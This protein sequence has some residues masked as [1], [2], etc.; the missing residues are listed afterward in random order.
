D[1]PGQ[2]LLL[3]A[4]LAQAALGQ[5]HDLGA[6]LG[7]LQ[8]SDLHLVGPDAGLGEGGPGGVDAGGVGPLQGQPG[9]EHLERPEAPGADD[10]RAQE[11]WPVAGA[12]SVAR[13]AKG[14]GEVALPR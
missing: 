9:A 4:V 11:Y 8:L 13:P 6:G 1:A 2:P 10:G 12:A 7:V 3:L 5:V 14:E